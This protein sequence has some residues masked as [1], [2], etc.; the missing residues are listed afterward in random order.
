MMIESSGQKI[1]K[2]L[3]YVFLIVMAAIMILPFLWISPENW[4]SN[5]SIVQ[6]LAAVKGLF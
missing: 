2:V 1:L 3:L 5:L 6:N 4:G